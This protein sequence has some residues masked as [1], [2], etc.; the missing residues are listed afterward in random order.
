MP[1]IAGNLLLAEETV[2]GWMVVED[3]TLVD[4]GDGAP[5]GT[6]DASGWVCPP[7]VNAHSHVADAFLRGQRGMPT[8]IPELVGPGGW[9]HHQ[10]ALA[11]KERAAGG[12]VQYVSEMAES[13]VNAFIDFRENGLTGTRFLADLRDQADWVQE[14]G[15]EPLAAE[16]L[17]M[18]RPQMNNFDPD[19][20][21]DLLE[22]VD[23]IGISGMRDF[24]EPNDI[25]HWADAAAAAGKPWAVHLS[26]DRH[27]DLEAV[28]PLQPDHVVHM[29]HAMPGDLRMAAD[30]GLPIVACPRSNRFF[31]HDA[32]IQQML[33]A[34]CLVALGTDN[35][36][37][38]TGD[39]FEEAAM[40]RR[41]VRGIDD[42]TLLRMMTHN[43]RAV[44]GLPDWEPAK[45]QPIE[46]VVYDEN[47]FP[48]PGME[49]APIVARS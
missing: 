34:G 12:V 15:L 7:A 24:P 14:E 9:K 33:E 29:V 46:V 42:E 47:P 25:H 21:E 8:S 27:D 4:W 11:R 22:V 45:G 1:L 19:E 20:A 49:R 43:G 41:L 31:G 40:V 13:G 10:L 38:Q 5:P 17:I 28:M 2:S 23:G 30:V 37:L 16:P 26:E 6:P 36:M 35:G 48:I 39:L 44:A 3:G 18:G 32:P